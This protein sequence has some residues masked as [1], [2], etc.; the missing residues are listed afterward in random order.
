[1]DRSAIRVINKN[2]F[3]VALSTRDRNIYLEGTLVNGVPVEEYFTLA[4]LEFINNRTPV[5]RDG[6]IEFDESEK[7]EVYTALKIPRWKETCI[8]EDEIDDMLING[9]IEKMEKIVAIV[10]PVQIDRIFSHMQR[11]IKR[12][13]VDISTRVQKVVE[14]RRKEILRGDVNSRLRLRPVGNPSGDPALEKQ[15]S[16]MVAEQVAKQLELM[17]N[18]SGTNAED[19]NV[20]EAPKDAVA[21]EEKTT[22][23]KKAGRPASRA[24]GKRTAAKKS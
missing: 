13:Q 23:S 15:V 4:E 21:D 1:M 14:E 19:K 10:N 2:Q 18:A 11:L 9:T 12:G 6:I 5:I 22:A 16:E 8:F 20:S 24:A 3:G 17:R 7:E